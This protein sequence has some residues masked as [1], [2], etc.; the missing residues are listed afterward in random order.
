MSHRNCHIN[1]LIP[2]ALLL[3]LAISIV[4]CNTTR[5]SEAIEKST[6]EKFAFDFVESDDLTFILKEAKAQ[7]K[8]VFVDVYTTWCLPCKMM[9]K[10]V[11]NNEE[12]ADMF[13]DKFINY[14]VD[15]EQ[16]NGLIV[17]FNYDVT[18]YPTLLFLNAKGEV[19]ERNEGAANID[20]MITMANKAIVQ[21]EQGH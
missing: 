12:T 3:V 6:V 13:N 1:L 5:K 15:A 10:T 21:N 20:E 7:H 8:L 17:A 18:K 19:L 14:R 2:T 11:F 16:D 9:D 4:S